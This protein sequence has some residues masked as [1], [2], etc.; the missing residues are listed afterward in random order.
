MRILIIA[1]SIILLGMAHSQSQE[2]PYPTDADTADAKAGEFIVNSGALGDYKADFG[3]LIVLMRIRGF[4]LQNMEVDPP[5][6][7]G[8]LASETAA[9]RSCCPL[10]SQSSNRTPEGSSRSLEW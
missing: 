2:L 6:R 7:R 8:R 3:I 10:A 5:G 9:R 1:L 4:A